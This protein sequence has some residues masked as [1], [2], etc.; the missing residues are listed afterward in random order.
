[1]IK[2]ISIKLL[3][4]PAEQAASAIKLD[5]RQVQEPRDMDQTI[6]VGVLIPH[7]INQPA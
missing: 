3:E 4:Q 7:R 6:E 5:L 1:L 2:L